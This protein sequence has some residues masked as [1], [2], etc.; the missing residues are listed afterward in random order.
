MDNPFF[1]KLAPLGFTALDQNNCVGVWNNYAVTL[2][3]YSGSLYWIFVAIRIPARSKELKKSL[4]SALQARLGKRAAVANVMPNF[5]QGQLR[6]SHVENELP[7]ISAFLDTATGLLR[8]NGVGPADTCAVT[9]A[10]NPDSLCLLDRPG[11]VGFQPVCASAIRREDYEAQAKVE[12][13]E[14]NGSYLTGF[15]G[16]LLGALVGVGVNLLTI[17]FLQR[18]FSLLFAL[19]PIFAMFG[20]KLFKGKTNKVSLVIVIVLSLLCVP[21][22]EFLADSIQIAREYQAPFGEVAAEVAKIFFDAEVLAETGPEMLKLLLFMVLGLFLG[23][24]YLR[25]QLNSTKAGS[26]RLQLESL[27]PNPNYMAADYAAQ[28]QYNQVPQPE[29]NQV[30]PQ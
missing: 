9:G 5:L 14:N 8:E 10:P 7:E 27:R 23:Y 24:G 17:V 1:A 18:I 4:K 15:L 30:P 22:M 3:R 19:V 6:F 26:L 25:G 13:N 16:A 20:Y 28:G 2:R 12:E 21:L 11:F 29:Y